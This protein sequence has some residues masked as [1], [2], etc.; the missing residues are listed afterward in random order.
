MTEFT[1]GITPNSSPAAITSG[2]DHNLWFVEQNTDKIGRI[3]LTGNITEY[4]IPTSN[5]HP[6]FIAAGP[7]LNLWFTENF[8]SQIGAITSGCLRYS[9]A[10][11][12]SSKLQGSGPQYLN[13]R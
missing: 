7:D 10:M 1:T 5:A 13:N 9:A 11:N 4:A 12:C 6:F 3:T 2:P 8:S